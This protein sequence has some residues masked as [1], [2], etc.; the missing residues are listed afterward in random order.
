MISEIQIIFM[1]I[2]YSTATAPQEQHHTRTT[3]KHH[4]STT[5][6]H[7]TSTTRH[8]H[9][10]TSPAPV[11][12]LVTLSEHHLLLYITRTNNRAH[13]AMHAR[14]PHTTRCYTATVCS[15]CY[16]V[17]LLLQCVVTATVCSCCYSVQFLLLMDALGI[18]LVGP[19]LRDQS[20]KDMCCTLAELHQSITVALRSAGCAT[21]GS[22]QEYA[23]QRDLRYNSAAS[24]MQRDL[25]YNGAASLMQRDLR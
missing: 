25:R 1:K 2:R 6:H 3:T 13:V 21:V 20:I 19:P 14:L 11:E 18:L 22:L 12:L 15:C 16:S 24:L 10:S 8:H 7:H 4:T 17:Q 9:T 23:R 5:P